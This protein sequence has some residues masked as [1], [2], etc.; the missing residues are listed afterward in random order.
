LA[1][2][3][4]N[5]RTAEIELNPIKHACRHAVQFYE[6]DSALIEALGQHIG[7]AL[8]SGDTAIV[9]ATEAHRQG[10]AEELRLRKIDASAATKA[11]LF[12]QLDAAETLA[13][14][15]VG[16]GPDKQK[17]QATVGALVSQAAAR[18]KPG[19]RLVA[20]GE[21][22]ALLWAEGKR[23]ATLRLEE[24]WNELSE[25]YT[26]DLLCGYPIGVFDRMEHRQ[27]FF[28]ICGEHTEVN[29]AESYP[30]HGSDMQRRRSAARLQQKAKA[31]ETEIRIGQ[32]RVQLLQQVTRA[33]T[34]ELDIVTDTFSFSSAAA[35]LL[36]F[37]SSSRVR[38]GQL[39]DLMYYSGDRE[40]VFASLQAAQRH[41]KD[42]KT[43]FRVRQGDGTRIVAMQGKTFYNSGAPLMLGVVSDVTPAGENNAAPAPLDVPG[44]KTALAN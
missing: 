27:L 23:D 2:I 39:M 12:I 4:P 15:M 20:Y 21:M 41:R 29:P 18:T 44:K 24:L 35:K 42:F 36:G 32:E 8:E 16:G 11:G 6:H 10:L 14:F 43:T 19:C 33:G 13:S 38:L 7:T 5:R 31:L 34:W 3:M 17:F 9:I 28:S 30:V 26:F 22:V 40:A 25:Q 37:P 1:K